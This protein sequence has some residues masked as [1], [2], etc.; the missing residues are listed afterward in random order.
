MT[1]QTISSLEDCRKLSL[2]ISVNS[3]LFFSKN[4]MTRLNDTP[5]DI[6]SVV[7]GSKLLKILAL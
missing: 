7:S 1:L 6:L 5:K 4:S 3:M 2:Q